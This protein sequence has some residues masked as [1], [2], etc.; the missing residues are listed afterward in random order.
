MGTLATTAARALR[1]LMLTLARTSEVRLATS[2]EIEGEVWSLSAKRTK[3]NES[4][5]IPLVAEA[6]A[7]A[8][9]P[10]QHVGR[11]RPGN[12]MLKSATCC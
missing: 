11:R 9:G 3:T 6:Q 8:A 7:L 12:R 1:F 4:R 5:R 10:D 2:D